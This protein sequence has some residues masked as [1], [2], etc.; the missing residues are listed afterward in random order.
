MSK[1]AGRGGA[2]EYVVKGG[3]FQQVYWKGV[4]RWGR[5]DEVDAKNT[6]SSV[7]DNQLMHLMHVRRTTITRRLEVNS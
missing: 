4:S 6:H 3:M 2:T 7:D 5:I 1:N